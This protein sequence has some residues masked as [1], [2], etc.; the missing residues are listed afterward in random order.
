MSDIYQVMFNIFSAFL[1]GT[2]VSSYIDPRILYSIL[3]RPHPM[4]VNAPLLPAT[5]HVRV[6]VKQMRIELLKLIGKR[7]LGIR[8]ELGFDALKG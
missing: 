7:C 8:Q 1:H 4:D 6:Q 5:L 2:N 3:L